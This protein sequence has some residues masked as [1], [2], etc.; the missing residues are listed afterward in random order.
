MATFLSCSSCSSLSASLSNLWVPAKGHNR[1]ASRG[2]GW[3]T[4]EKLVGALDFESPSRA[5]ADLQFCGAEGALPAWGNRE[6]T[7]D[8]GFPVPTWDGESWAP[9]SMTYGKE[10]GVGTPRLESLSH[11]GSMGV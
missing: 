2:P 9:M 11:T 5:K 1:P 10:E 6:G 8:T 3:G 7:K 4:T